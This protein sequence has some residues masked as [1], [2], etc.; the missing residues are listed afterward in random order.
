MKNRINWIRNPFTIILILSFTY[1]VTSYFLDK[2]CN[3]LFRDWVLVL[4]ILI[5][6]LC[7]LIIEIGILT[8]LNNLFE[9]SLSIGKIWKR[10]IQLVFIL[11]IL[12]AN[13]YIF[14]ICIFSINYEEVGVEDYDGNKY[15][16]RD[17]SGWLSHH[18]S[19]EYHTYINIFIY[20]KDVKHSQDFRFI[21]GNYLDA[22]ENK[23]NTS[24]TT[25]NTS[26]VPDIT[27][28][29]VNNTN[30][31]EEI[32]I[33]SRNVEYIQKINNNLNYGFYLIDRAGHQYSYA[34]VQSN[35]AGLS[36]KVAYQ[37]SASSE[38]YYGHF[39]DEEIGFI[40]FGSSEDLSLFMTNDG[41]L[42][43]KSVLINLPEENRNMIYVKDIK[44]SGEEIELMLG[45]PSW[46]NSNKSIKYISIDKGLSWDLQI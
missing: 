25:L 42:A 34:F 28:T 5:L 16:V 33:I 29:N 40:N 39:L 23:E 6:T 15:V 38:I 12:L 43:W 24:N 32:E 4:V 31:K 37:F 26:D 19:Y 41:G 1:I 2:Y 44:M 20:D 22:D 7:G 35:D 36:W 9:K 27:D 14:I 18:P 11:L 46:T 30:G 21:W 8:K 10:I 17:T 45:V 3:M 13:F